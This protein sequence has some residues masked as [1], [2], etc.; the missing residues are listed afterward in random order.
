MFSPVENSLSAV[1][2]QIVRQT[3]VTA[4]D[5]SD[6]W[7]CLLLPYDSRKLFQINRPMLDEWTG[8]IVGIRTVVKCVVLLNIER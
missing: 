1:W 6:P 8:R 2:Q 3:T 7:N 5:G 4:E